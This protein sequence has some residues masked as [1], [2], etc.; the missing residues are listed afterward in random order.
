VRFLRVRVLTRSAGRRTP[1]LQSQARNERAIVRSL[2][3]SSTSPGHEPRLSISVLS[4]DDPRRSFD[5]L[6][7]DA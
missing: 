1:A 4:P 5:G 6:A 3:M 2:L 7:A